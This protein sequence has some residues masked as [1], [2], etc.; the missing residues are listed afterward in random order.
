MIEDSNFIR[1][2]DR[3]FDDTNLGIVFGGQDFSPAP[4][5]ARLWLSGY[6]NGVAQI[7]ALSAKQIVVRQGSCPSEQ[8]IYVTKRVTDLGPRDCTDWDPAGFPGV[9]QTQTGF[10]SRLQL[11]G[12]DTTLLEDGALAVQDVM[13]SLCG[14]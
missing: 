9:G 10:D 1:A 5:H 6:D 3:S 2:T 7:P 11:S 8:G 14:S 4:A 13:L 12:H